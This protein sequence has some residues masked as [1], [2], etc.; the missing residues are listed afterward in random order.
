MAKAIEYKLRRTAKRKGI[1]GHQ[2][3][4]NKELL[5][6]IYK[7]KRITENLS[8]NEL[9]KITKMQNLSLN[10]LKKIERMNNLSL[11]ELNQIA[12]TRH[13]KNYKDMS[14]ED[15]LIALLKS[16]PSH[17]ELLKIDDS[18]TEIGE[19]KKLFNNLRNNFSREEIKKYREKFHKKERVY[20]YLKGKDS[21][22][23]R[24]KRVLKNIERYF[25]KLKKDLNKIK[26]YQYNIT[27][28]ISHLFNE[29]TKEDYYEPIEIKSASDGSYI[30][31][32]S[33]GDSDD[34]LSLA[35]YINIIRP[36]LRDMIN[37]HKA[38]GE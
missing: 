7:L 31:Y 37:N 23:T 18:N 20:N 21:L 9:N 29:I 35:E 15:L 25:K 3:K 30:Q 33:R 2:N 13:I 28:D 36:Y 6:I 12:A 11:N 26:I 10:K 24:E 14:R 16:N 8:K 17:T 32:E 1:L 5:R 19:T 38:Q 4:S 34:N 27:S 22:T